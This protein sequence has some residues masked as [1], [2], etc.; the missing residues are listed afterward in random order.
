MARKDIIE[1]HILLNIQRYGK[2]DP[3]IIIG[4]VIGE[5]PST[6]KDIPVLK[7]EIEK[8]IAE[9]KKLSKK[10]LE[11]KL[12]QLPKE[13][14]KD[15][16][17]QL[18]EL[19]KVSAPYTFRFEPSPTG[20][21]H[22]GHTIILLLNSEYAKKYKGKLIIRIADTNPEDIYMPA[23]EMIIK[24]AEW[25]TQ[26]KVTPIIQ[27]S[28]L[29][30]YYLHAQQL[31]DEGHAYVCTC[32]QGKF[33]EL[34]T[35]KQAC[36]C[37]SLEVKEQKERWQKMF[38]GY[39][40]GEAV[41]RIK[42]D[43]KHPNP[44]VRDWPAFRINDTPHPRVGSKYR[45]W[46]LMNFAITIDDHDN[47]MTHVIRGKDHITNM[48]RQLY[49]FKY[50]NWEVP[51]YIHIGR[52]N[53]KGLRIS[54]SEFR[55]AIEK[56]QYNGWDDPRLP[57]IAAFKRRGLQPQ[58]F[59]RYI[60]ELGPSKVDK[61]ISFEEFMKAIYS[62][63]RAAID[64]QTHRYFFVENPQ[65]VTIKNAPKIKAEVPI[66]PD[67]PSHGIRHLPTEGKFYI[68][69][70]LEKGKVYRFMHLY[71]IKDNQF[72][73]IELQPDLNARLI[74]WLPVS[75]DLV[76]VKIV[77]PDMS[78]KTGLAEHTIKQVKVDQV[79]QFERKCFCRLDR[80]EKDAYVFYYTHP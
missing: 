32:G 7:K 79:I 25:I 23:Y 4:K 68:E 8:V 31:V 29:D 36:P 27:S 6:K 21:L 28:R 41:L 65:E 44:A 75:K 43:V 59:V 12:S 33:K 2:T 71:N 48:D 1:K 61:T 77:M 53:F 39:E 74:H 13:E 9:V 51:E 19:K 78:I 46:P 26:Q 38:S 62:Y 56:G 70:K 57:T 54:T 67:V 14:K 18:P 80:I 64:K 60:T 5:D 42:T 73:S 69:D 17:K 37:R 22:I 47:G 3:G 72:H 50:F 45:V 66:H 24:D 58:A 40:M 52:I 49:I 15:T 76:K 63:N 20:P 30:D 34:I 35:K 16:T 55:E 11:K 10:D